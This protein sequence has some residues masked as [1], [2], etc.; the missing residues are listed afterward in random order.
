M[1]SFGTSIYSALCLALLVFI[2]ACGGKETES[3]SAA[4]PGSDLTA[5]Q[6]EHGIGPVTEVMTLASIDEALADSGAALFNTKCAACHKLDERYVGPALR[7]VTLR[8]SPAYIVNMI[9][10]PDEMIKSHPEA[11]LLLA[12]YMTMMPNQNITMA[13]ARA[14]LEYL[15]RTGLTSPETA[16]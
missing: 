9:I 11:R 12:E 8:R 4:A 16:P 6:L 1:T 13:D 7:E 14:L 10:N 5:F 3:S 15:R 2:G